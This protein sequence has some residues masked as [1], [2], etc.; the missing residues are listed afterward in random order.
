[1]NSFVSSHE[2]I[3]RFLQATGCNWRSSVYLECRECEH[4]TSH[5]CHDL[6][7][8]FDERAEPVFMPLHDA[9]FYWDQTIDKSEC[10]AVMP[11]SVF[12]E[13]YGQ[14]LLRHVQDPY[15]C[16]ISDLRISY[17]PKSENAFPIFP[18]L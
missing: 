16:F 9:E 14:W 4:R 15:K 3:R 1:M 5:H 8:A 18:N 12:K 11:T 6:L 13:L 7:C 10:L 17:E 2:N